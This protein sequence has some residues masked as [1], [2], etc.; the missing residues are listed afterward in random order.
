MATNQE[1][2]GSSPSGCAIYRGEPKARDTNGTN[3]PEIAPPSSSLPRY[4]PISARE[5]QDGHPATFED[6]CREKWG[7]SRSYAYRLM[8]TKDLLSPIGDNCHFRHEIKTESQARELAKVEPD[9]RHAVEIALREFD[10]LSNVEI[11]RICAV[12][13]D[14]VRTM[15]Q[16]PLNGGCESRL[17]ADG[18][19][20]KMPVMRGEVEGTQHFN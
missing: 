20:R 18:K 2:G 6:Y 16:P 9:K 15:R 7:F 11:A 13:D 14:L 10:A 3:P 17:G 19:I 1:V 5:G 12:G 4:G 8:I